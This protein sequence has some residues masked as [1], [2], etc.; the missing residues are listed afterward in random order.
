[1]SRSIEAV[2]PEPSVVSAGLV[3][4]TK[5]SRGGCELVCA[6]PLRSGWI[7]VAGPTAGADE[8]MARHA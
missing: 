1:M 7:G 5:A 2:G 8:V 3:R 4:A 6:M